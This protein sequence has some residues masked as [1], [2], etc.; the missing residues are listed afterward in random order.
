MLFPVPSIR[1]QL[2]LIALVVLV[3]PWIGIQTIREMETLLRQQQV[4]SQLN[5]AATIREGL[6]PVYE[7]LTSHH[8]RIQAS[9]DNSE[10]ILSPLPSKV[11][12]DGYIDDWPEDAI[13]LHY[14]AAGHLLDGR[15]DT[16]LSVDLIAGY[17]TD[18]L[19]L[20]FDVNDDVLFQGDRADLLAHN[21]DQLMLG[22]KQSDGSLQQYV[23]GSNAPG[24]LSV[25]PT[26]LSDRQENRIHAEL[27]AKQG[28]YTI[29]LYIPRPM[30]P[31]AIAFAFMDRDNSEAGQFALIGNIHPDNKEQYGI[32]FG[33]DIPIRNQ[34]LPYQHKN[35]RI[36]VADSHGNVLS[37]IGQIPPA[38]E[39]EDEH[40]SL[41]NR[42]YQILLIADAPVEHADTPDY[43]LNT[44]YVR[45]A[46]GGND[47]H[48][49][50]KPSPGNE[51]LAVAVPLVIDNQVK[52]AL[53]VE[54]STQAIS[55]IR[56]HAIFNIIKMTLLAIAV[57]I[58]VLLFYAAL[59]IRRIHRLNIQLHTAVSD[60][61]R[62]HQSIPRSILNDEI[63]D[64]SRGIADMV[65]RLGEYQRYLETM[66]S[67]LSHELRT[68]LTVVQSSLENLQN[69]ADQQKKNE[70]L[71]RANDGLQRLR[72]ILI[73]LTE[74]SRLE[75]AL[76]TT[77]VE[78]FNLVTVVKGCVEGY[79]QAYPDVPFEFSSEADKHALSGSPELM[80]QLLDKLISNAIDFRTPGTPIK[81]SITQYKHGCNLTVANQ[82][83]PLPERL[84][85]TLFDSMV[86]E[87]ERR[88]DTPHLGL[89]LY[90]ARLLA[91][92]HGGR[93][94]ANND[95][96]GVRF[97]VALP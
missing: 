50:R 24:W 88:D 59:L 73:N 72:T 34:L 97:M 71:E 37:R 6:K 17:Q 55:N 52:G 16:N 7:R 54:E 46:L 95:N 4:Q 28:G 9:A 18:G 13:R 56:Q 48:Q 51:Y 69:E 41:M 25:I 49:F 96:D 80:A 58:I 39:Q 20:M 64:L 86:S 3:L 33:Q 38:G 31:D 89:G 67:K 32:L 83:P 35:R 84:Q 76:K 79:R 75:N 87:R 62:L 5:T 26:D 66:A 21:T 30:V 23:I 81:V 42:L 63:G 85:D 19:V 22:L 1:N 92:F 78:T 10:I 2:L 74:A 93:V 70:L 40:F 36:V 57:V 53:V 11:S 91:E 27:Q 77:D 12:I 65:D 8:H 43:R 82:G 44:D 60:D 15:P 94:R 68:P 14:D 47:S 61:G 29:E 45:I 90:I